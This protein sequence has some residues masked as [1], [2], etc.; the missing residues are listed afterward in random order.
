M[1]NRYLNA[2]FTSSLSI[3]PI[4]LLVCILSWTPILSLKAND[5]IM[6]LIGGII[7][8]LGLAL[9]QIGATTGLTKVGEYMGSSLSRQKDIFIVIVFA[10][11]L[12]AL[13]TCAEPSILIATKQVTIIPNNPAL[14]A[15]VLIGSIA[16]GVGVFVVVG[17]IRIILHKSLKIWYVFFYMITFMLICLVAVDPSKAELLPFIFDS[18]GITTGSATVPFILSLGLGVA[19]VRGGKNA[20]SDSFGLVGM[21]SIGPIMAMTLCILIQSNIPQYVYTPAN[22]FDQN[23]I[24]HFLATLLPNNGRLG[25]MIEVAI[26]LSPILIIFFVYERLFIK[27]PKSKILQLIVGFAFCFVGL[28]LFLASASATMTPMGDIVGRALGEYWSDNSW[29]IILVAF[30]IGLVTILC[31]PAVHVLTSQ[32]ESISSGQI[33]KKTVLLTLSLGVGIAIMLAA[34]RAIYNFSIL[35][36]M[37]PGYVISLIMM[38]ICPDI[39]TAIAFDSGGTASGPMSTSFVLPVIIGLYS[40]IGTDKYSADNTYNVSYYGEAFGLVALIALTPIIAVQ[41]LGIFV[42]FKQLRR[43]I[44]ARKAIIEVDDVQI[45]HFIKGV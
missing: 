2:L 4:I 27:L 3:A 16:L 6:L 19:I 38:F 17:V 21:A 11:A 41:S 31:E 32:I 7:L 44:A 37:V 15:I 5:Y 43:R 45:I 40:V 33:S 30:I 9:F 34:I 23:I 22:S 42:E 39:F 13:V 14:N 24:G 12:G 35:Y 8:I 10:F 1:K 18:G 28:S 26:A 25:S 36:Y 20:T 29:V